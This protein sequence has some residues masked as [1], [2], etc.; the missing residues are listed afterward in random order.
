MPLICLTTPCRICCA[1]MVMLRG[2]YSLHR[3][4][5]GTRQRQAHRLCGQ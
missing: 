2:H 3:L 5:S 4:C 1:A